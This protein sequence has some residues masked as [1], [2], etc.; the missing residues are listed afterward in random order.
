MTDHATSLEVVTREVDGRTL[1]GVTADPAQLERTMARFAKAAP[2]DTPAVVE[3]PEAAPPTQEQTPA[4]PAGAPLAEGAAESPEKAPRGKKRFDQLTF[5]KSEAERAAK[6]A[7]ARAAALEA[8]LAALEQQ[9]QAPAAPPPAAPV[10]PPAP[11]TLP[12]HLKSYDA[13]LSQHPDS[14]YESYR[15]ARD[16]WRR[17]H[18]VAP[19]FDAQIRSRIEADR[20]SRTVD[21]QIADTRAKGRTMYPDFDAVLAGP[22]AQI[23]FTADR[24]MAILEHPASP[25]LQY[26]IAKDPALAQKLATCSPF[27]FGAELVRLTPAASGAPAASPGSPGSV[28]PPSPMQPVGSGS[29]TTSPSSADLASKGYDFDKSGYR[30]RRAA[31]RGVTRRR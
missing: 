8:R 20:A 30:E 15:D 28:T 31:E 4:A 11:P 19:Q 18:L 5:E 24:L 23:P 27:A 1:S 14:D 2:T 21:D 12:A 13:Y 9:R 22:G 26:V 6:A 10:Q 17:E 16:D 29:K 7:E 25:H 3:S